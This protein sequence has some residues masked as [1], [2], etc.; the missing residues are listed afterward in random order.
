MRSGRPA[1]RCFNPRAREGR[2]RSRTRS[3]ARHGRFNP[4]AR[5]GRDGGGLAAARDQL[6]SIHAP[7]KGAT[8][9]I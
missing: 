2:D 3:E 5:E 1:R 4:R 8:D 7:V 6:V 9:P